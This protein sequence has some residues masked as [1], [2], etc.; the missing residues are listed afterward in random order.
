MRAL[1]TG[2][3]G[4][5]GSH[6]AR[7]LLGAN[8]SVRGLVRA[9]SDLRSLQGLELELIRGD[10]CDKVSLI[11]AMEHCDVVF[12]TAAH[13]AY[14]GTRLEQLN[15]LAVEGTTNVLEAAK[16]SAIKRVVLTSSSVVCGSSHRPLVRNEMDQLDAGETT[17]YVL[18]KQ[19]Q[20]QLAFELARVL[21][22]E[23]VAACPTMTIGPR[24][25]RLGPSNGVIVAYLNDPLRTSF[26]G[27][28]NMVSVQD[29][30]RGHVLL[31]QRGESG[32]RYLLGGENIEWQ[33]VHRW[34]SQLCGIAG[35]Y[36]QANHTASFLAAS[37]DELL[38]KLSNRQPLTTRT[39]ARMVGRYYWYDH[40]KA[41]ALGYAPGTARQAVAQ[42]V[43]WLVASQHISRQVRIGLRLS[44]EAFAAFPSTPCGT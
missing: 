36:W 12:H 11:A 9:S 42:A 23:L 14:A 43:S 40:S 32:Q 3:N 19:K 25:H 41:Q 29:V 44:R 5:I 10:V 21:G 16:E 39:Q 27:G 18:S 8:H 26:P 22:L 37:S 38:S 30:A 24:D 4:L 34:I 20:E 35:P 28:C 2:A 13:F 15:Q 17:P 7:E 31:A 6:I 1:I 33:H